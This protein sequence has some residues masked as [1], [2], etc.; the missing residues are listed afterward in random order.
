[1]NRECKKLRTARPVTKPRKISVL[2]RPQ[3]CKHPIPTKRGKMK[4]SPKAPPI[5]VNATRDVLPGSAL[6]GPAG[7]L[8][9]VGSAI[10]RA[11]GHIGVEVMKTIRGKAEE[12]SKREKKNPR[13]E[14]IS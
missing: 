3:F 4:I 9:G 1:L 14:R 7:A 2:T 13:A 10:T 12:E 8:A 6:A 11:F 5:K